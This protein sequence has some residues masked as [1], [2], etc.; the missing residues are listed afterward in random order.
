MHEMAGGLDPTRPGF[1]D[2]P[3]R[4]SG[5]EV[6]RR[7]VIEPEGPLM[8]PPYRS[9]THRVY[10]RDGDQVAV[11]MPPFDLQAEWRF[12]HG[13]WLAKRLCR[14]LNAGGETASQ[15][16]ADYHAARTIQVPEGTPHTPGEVDC[17]IDSQGRLIRVEAAE[18]T[19]EAAERPGGPR[20][21]PTAW[22]QYEEWAECGVGESPGWTVERG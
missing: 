15:A 10:N 18:E 21:G 9:W 12:D 1:L 20:S 14:C 8:R 22:S 16:I 17:L 3:G 19:R 4:D 7:Q 6:Y 13:E 5:L 2:A 11:F